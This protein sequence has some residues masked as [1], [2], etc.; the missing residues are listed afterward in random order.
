VQSARPKLPRNEILANDGAAW[1]AII[2]VM[3]EPWQL[4]DSVA[5]IQRLL[6]SF[7]RWTGREL[8]PARGTPED[9]A[10]AVYFAA[11][12]ILSHGTQAD[13]IL[14][15]GNAAAL[16]LWEMDWP[17]F[18]STPSRLTAERH[19]REIRARLMAQVTR[20]GFIDNYAGIRISNSGRRFEIRNATVWNIVDERGVR[21]GQAATFT[22]W[23]FID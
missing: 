18:T 6:N 15:Y 12:V 21:C 7:K 19:E 22:Q 14:N 5:H 20:D 2:Q 13:P 16:K 17:A 1:R 10:C 4:A 23:K 11:K 8:I 9:D 3:I